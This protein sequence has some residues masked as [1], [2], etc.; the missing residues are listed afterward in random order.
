MRADYVALKQQS[1]GFAIY[2]GWFAQGPTNASLASVALYTSKV[3][4]F[5]AL[6]AHEGADFP[7][8]FARIKELSRLPK[9]QRDQALEAILTERTA[10]KTTGTAAGQTR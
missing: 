4:S 5:R 3:P 1:G 6:L 7:R 8:F 10:A 9:A 2:D